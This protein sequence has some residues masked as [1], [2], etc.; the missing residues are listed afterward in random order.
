MN[1]W[2]LNRKLYADAGGEIAID[3]F[4]EMRGPDNVTG[5]GQGQTLHVFPAGEFSL[6]ASYGAAKPEELLVD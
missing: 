3:A 4:W 1:A 6:T 5:S 2:V